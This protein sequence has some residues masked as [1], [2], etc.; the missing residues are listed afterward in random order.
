[1]GCA[2]ATSK[3]LSPI[4]DHEGQELPVFVA[5]LRFGITF[6]LIPS[7]KPVDGLSMLKLN[8]ISHNYGAEANWHLQM[9]YG[10][11]F[12]QEH[13][14]EVLIGNISVVDAESPSSIS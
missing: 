1:M 12:H 5:S 4:L 9:G 3:Q 14:M 8:F 10:L 2:A 6:A 11:L 7:L 13:F